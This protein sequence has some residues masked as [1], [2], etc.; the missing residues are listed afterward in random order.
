M[1]HKG[2]LHR[3]NLFHCV[4]DLLLCQICCLTMR[5]LFAAMEILEPL[6]LSDAINLRDPIGSALFFGQLVEA[7]NYHLDG[8][9]ILQ[10]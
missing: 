10:S 6:L 1:I 8:S 5:L 2:V 4:H 3:F 7:E 9:K